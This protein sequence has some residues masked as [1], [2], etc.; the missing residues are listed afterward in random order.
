MLNTRRSHIV[1]R[2]VWQAH[3]PRSCRNLGLPCVE[4]RS[5]R[6]T[7]ILHLI[8]QGVELR[9]IAKWQGHRDARLI[10]SRYGEYI[11]ADHEKKELEK[12]GMMA[13]QR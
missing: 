7:L 2:P 9:L 11:D 4:I 3:C 8:Q 1:P 5:L 12:L 10:L 13:S 6:R